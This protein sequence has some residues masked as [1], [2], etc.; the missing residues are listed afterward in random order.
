MKIDLVKA[1]KEK[2]SPH[3]QR[4]TPA[5]LTVKYGNFPFNRM[6]HAYVSIKQIAG[7]KFYV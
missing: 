5:F 6:V 7:S 4:E 3:R 2:K 1:R